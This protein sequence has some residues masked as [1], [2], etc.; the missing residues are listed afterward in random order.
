MSDTSTP[1]GRLDSKLAELR[2]AFDDLRADL[3]DAA[4]EKVN[5]LSAKLDEVQAAWAEWDDA[6]D[7]PVNDDAE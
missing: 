6:P 7:E 4:T 2:A 1:G 3:G 5:A